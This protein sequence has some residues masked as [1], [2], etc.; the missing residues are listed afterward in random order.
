MIHVHLLS[1]EMDGKKPT[2]MPKCIPM[3]TNPINPTKQLIDSK[4]EI[5]GL[6]VWY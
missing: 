4:D 3:D 2:Q 5:P 6:S 1:T